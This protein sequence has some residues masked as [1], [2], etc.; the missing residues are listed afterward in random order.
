MEKAVRIVLIVLV[1]LMLGLLVL[2]F[3]PYWTV[4]ETNEQVSI[5]GYT[6]WPLDHEDLT[7]QFEDM[8][9]KKNY[10]LN[11]T[12]NMPV[13][14]FFFTLLCV[15]CTVLTHAKKSWVGVFPFVAGIGAVIGYLTQP[16][17]Q[18]NSIWTVH[19]ALGIVIALVSL[20]CIYTFVRE[21]V[22][23]AAPKK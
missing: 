20:L 6:W 2:Q 5:Q 11:D 14:V 19:M 18:L 9:G 16:V 23:K 13:L 1:V 15:I 17:Y 3:L 7:E 4:T 12:V 10:S 8:Y 22:F 21:L